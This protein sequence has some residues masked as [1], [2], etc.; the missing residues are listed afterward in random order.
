[1][2]E[3]A[4]AQ[5]NLGADTPHHLQDRG[6]NVYFAPEIPYETKVVN[7]ANG[8]VERFATGEHRPERGY[9]ADYG[10]LE[11]FCREHGISFSETNGQVSVDPIAGRSG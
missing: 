5:N 9:Y 8:R 11:R 4:W 6:V 3:F 1:V 2:E 10:S 7:L